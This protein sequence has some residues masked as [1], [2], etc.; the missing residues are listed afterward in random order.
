MMQAWALPAEF[1]LQAMISLMMLTAS[2][3]F[4]WLSRETHQ[5]QD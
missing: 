5:E 4:L 1:Y 3:S 2:V